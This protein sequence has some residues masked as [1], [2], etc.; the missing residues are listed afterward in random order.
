MKAAHAVHCCIIVSEL[1]LAFICFVP[2]F[3]PSVL[4]ISFTQVVQ[5]A[6]QECCR[7]NL[8]AQQPL[9]RRKHQHMGKL[10]LG[11]SLLG[12]PE[13]SHFLQHWKVG[14]PGWSAMAPQ[15]ACCPALSCARHGCLATLRWRP[16]IL[17]SEW[18]CRHLIS[19]TLV[20][21]C[22]HR[23]G[24]EGHMQRWQSS[25]RDRTEDVSG[26]PFKPR[27]IA[28]SLSREALGSWS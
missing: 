7:S 14:D 10:R 24:D 26:C 1:F 15:T 13:C 9:H 2:C 8:Y 12:L 6:F 18:R 23:R 3:A 11:S 16:T 21:K 20:W 19:G 5:G 28:C 4:V 25:I 22:W 27:A 17:M